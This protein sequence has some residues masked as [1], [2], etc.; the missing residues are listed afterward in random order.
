MAAKKPVKMKARKTTLRAKATKKAS[1]RSIRQAK[2]IQEME[3]LRVDPS[4]T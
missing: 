2:N 4:E 3:A 1:P